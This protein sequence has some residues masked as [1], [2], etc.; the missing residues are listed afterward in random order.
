MA[1]IEKM[2]KKILSLATARRLFRKLR[3][4]IGLNG[5]SEFEKTLESY[6]EIVAKLAIKNASYEGR[7]VVKNK[8]VKEALKELEGES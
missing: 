5:Y 6:A 1:E 4:G 3:G 2:E 8:D 7:K